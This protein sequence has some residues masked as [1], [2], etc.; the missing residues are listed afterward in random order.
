[1]RECGGTRGGQCEAGDDA[2]EREL[3]L[4][5][6]EKLQ[7]DAFTAVVRAVNE[8]DAYDHKGGHAEKGEPVEAF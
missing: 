7:F 6:V 8:A 2:E 5:A 3:G 1:M 4:R